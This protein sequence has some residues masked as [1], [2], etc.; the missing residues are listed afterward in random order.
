MV[1][2]EVQYYYF[3]NNTN[4]PLTFFSALRRIGNK[5]QPYNRRILILILFRYHH[6]DLFILQFQMQVSNF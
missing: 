5:F 2:H 6:F 1:G 3:S 4:S